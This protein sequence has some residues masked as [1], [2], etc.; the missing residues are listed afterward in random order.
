L[1]SLFRNGNTAGASA[2]SIKTLKTAFPLDF[3]AGIFAF[4]S[5]ETQQTVLFQTCPLSRSMSL[6]AS[7]LHD[8]FKICGVFD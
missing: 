4:N 2:F 8:R 6:S 1:Q 3:I 5:P 7:H